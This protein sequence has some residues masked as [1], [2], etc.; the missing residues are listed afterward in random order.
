[1]SLPVALRLPGLRYRVGRVSEAPPGFVLPH[2]TSQNTLRLTLEVSGRLF[3]GFLPVV[4][5]LQRGTELRH[6]LWVVKVWRDGEFRRQR[7]RQ[8]RPA[9][10]GSSSLMVPSS[11]RYC[12]ATLLSGTPRSR[13]SVSTPSLLLSRKL[14][15]FA[16]ASGFW[17]SYQSTASAPV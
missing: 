2:R 4:D 17:S 5:I 9:T 13:P 6:N 12:T 16:A 8:R 1:M 11:V 14:I 10:E 7:L 3:H 15:S